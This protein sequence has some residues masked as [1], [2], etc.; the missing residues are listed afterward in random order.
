MATPN[1]PTLTVT[2]PSDLEIVMT[3][4]FDAPRELVFEAH[5]S[6]EHLKHWWGPRRYEL[7]VCDL[8]FRPGGAWRFVQRGADG[9]EHGFRGEFRE[10]IPP[11][12]IV[13]TFEY[14]GMP[15]HVSVETLTLEDIGGKTLLTARAV[16]DSVE[17]RDAMLQSGMEE[18]A[19]ETWDRLAEHLRAMATA[20]PTAGGLLIE[21]VF[22]APRELVWKAWAEP[23]L[24][25]RWFGPKGFTTPV[26]KIDFRVGGV[27]L[28]CMRS[29]EGQDYWSTGVYRE[30][31]PMERIVTTDS[32][33]DADGNVVPASH[34]GMPGDFPLE[35]LVTVTFEDL[36]AR[37]RMTLRHEGMPAGEMGEMAQQGWNES[38]DK[39]AASLSQD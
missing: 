36:G 6:C 32:F 8:D 35:M 11:E 17:D 27:S 16:Y 24:M 21:R 14:E 9:G 22:D 1:S 19:A 18:G 20:A 7:T 2:T 13:W 10:I 39:L 37:T 4:V 26:C 33:A 28:T 25:A 23:E 5:T 29:P 38:F 30:I 34:Y 12:R 3:R 15:G 31:V